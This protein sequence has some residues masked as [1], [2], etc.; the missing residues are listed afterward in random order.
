MDTAG[1]L[2]RIPKACTGLCICSQEVAQFASPDMEALT[3]NYQMQPFYNATRLSP[4]L[5]PGFSL[6]LSVKVD[7]AFPNLRH[8]TEACIYFQI[9]HIA[10]DSFTG[11]FDSCP[12]SM[13][14]KFRYTFFVSSCF[15][16]NST[17]L[18]RTLRNVLSPFIAHQPGRNASRTKVLQS[19][20]SFASPRPDIL[21]A[22]CKLHSQD[23]RSK[24]RQA[25]SSDVCEQSSSS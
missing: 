21:A 13:H 18:V 17:D 2:L 9:G 25:T 8:T 10:E 5:K 12:R 24:A 6:R 7:H 15:F 19:P 23:M 11:L 1:F 14:T 16:H 20:S 3:H 22:A 4:G